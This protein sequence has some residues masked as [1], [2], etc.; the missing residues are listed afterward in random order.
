MS[1]PYVSGLAGLIWSRHYT[2]TVSAV[3][4]LIFHTAV[5]VDEVG[6]DERTGWGRIDAQ[7]ALSTTMHIV[8]LPLLM[9]DSSFFNWPLDH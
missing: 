5:D 6:W 2:Y 4:G 9:Q 1:T 8:Y 3:A 7:R